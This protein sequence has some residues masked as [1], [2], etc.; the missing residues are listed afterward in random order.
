MGSATAPPQPRSGSPWVKPMVEQLKAKPGQWRIADTFPNHAAA[1]SYRAR[2]K[3][4]GA[5]AVAR[6]NDEGTVD[7]W[8]C[9][10]AS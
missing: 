8:V 10:E 5:D 9:W 2:F 3:A 1:T 6:L 7:L 4:L